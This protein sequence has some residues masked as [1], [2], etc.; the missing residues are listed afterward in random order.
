MT[1]ELTYLVYSV[2]LTFILLMIPATTKVL[3]NGLV[4]MV[5]PRD[6]LPEP[7]V[8]AA[9]AQRAAVNMIE[10]MVLFVPLFLAAQMAGIS[11]ESTILGVQ[12]FLTGR[13]AHAVVY[14]AGWPW[15]RT[16]AW[17]VAVVGMA[18]IVL[19]IV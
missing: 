4:T 6:S 11:N 16:L 12:L 10:N 3:Q 9:R 8:F 19:Q 5:G 2:G 14:L 1:V 18:M 13:I 7:S 17:F 15:V